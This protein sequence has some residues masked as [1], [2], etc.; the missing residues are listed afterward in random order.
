[1]SLIPIPFDLPVSKIKSIVATATK[2]I[3]L[4]PWL[5]LAFAAGLWIL[6]L[7][8]FNLEQMKD[9]GLVSVFPAAIIF[10]YAI[11]VFSFASLYFRKSVKDAVF[12]CHIL[13]LI[14]MLHATPQLLYG[15]LRYSWAWKHV[16][17]V[18]YII[19]HHAINPTI[20]ILS[21]YHNWPG[22]F[23]LNALFTELVG[24]PSAHV[25]A[26][27]GPVFFE[28][29]FASGLLALMRLFTAD[30]PKQWLGVWLFVLTNWIG[31][32]YFAPQ[33]MGY[34]LM[35]CI[36]VL[37]LREFGP[38]QPLKCRSWKKWLL[39]VFRFISLDQCLVE[40]V[41]TL[42]LPEIPVNLPPT[43]ASQWNLGVIV[44]LL[45]VTV[46]SSHQLTPFM[47]FLYVSALVLFGIVRWRALPF[48]MLAFISL[49]LV[50]PAH[51]YNDTVVGTTL[52]SFGRISGTVDSGL[53]D[54]ARVSS[55][56]ALVSWMGR[57]LSAL[58]IFLAGI[59]TYQRLRRGYLDLPAILLAGAPIIVLFLNSY[60]GEAI[61]RVY[62]F[63]L[64]PVVF[65][66]A[67]ALIPD[68][69]TE[70]NRLLPV[71]IG[72]L[73]MVLLVAF[74]FAYYGKERQYSFT[75][76]EVKAAEYIYRYAPPGSLLVEG[77]NNYPT[78]FLNYENFT[79]V[80]IDREPPESRARLLVDP[81]KVLYRWLS[82]KDRYTT[83]YLIITRSQKF[84][85][86]EIGKMPKHSLT[87]IEIALANS[88]KFE[89]VYS[90]KDAIVFKVRDD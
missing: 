60:G 76:D 56:Q 86:D 55:G 30:H 88:N 31:Q 79:Y 72:S 82:D 8:Y 29:L 68:E 84:Y 57:G 1:M 41:A 7:Q 6:S 23:A 80:A 81:V 44:L 11:L 74:L 53:V 87:Y 52:E 24:F 64:P 10:S 15:T 90:N 67:G 66:A 2:V 9:W 28:I 78:L 69:K 39:P 36:L 48:W 77:S 27:W 85:I 58:I 62:F 14:L 21:A 22:F 45:F 38:L 34:F 47:I 50:F 40:K 43:K 71:A 65:L 35:I 4:N 13:V 61:F 46:V 3:L 54:V 70:Q 33:A 18:D 26:G 75:K 51:S 17:I 59:G 63:M 16:G 49:W 19:R 89:I 20:K 42:K 73:S 5:S 25:Y 32:D 12:A 37:T 83:S